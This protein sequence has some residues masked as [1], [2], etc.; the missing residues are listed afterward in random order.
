MTGIRTAHFTTPG[1]Y[2]AE[3]RS[4]KVDL[5]VTAGGD[6][7]GELTW[8]NLTGLQLLWGREN[9]PRIAFVALRPAQAYISLQVSGNKP[10]GFRGLNL[11][12][13][14][15]VIHGVEERAHHRTS[16]QAEWCWISLSHDKLA[17]FSKASIGLVIRPPLEARVHPAET[18]EAGKLR[19]A[20][21]RAREFAEGRPD[22]INDVEPA[23]VIQ[24]NLLSAVVK[25]LAA[26]N[27]E[28]PLGS[29]ARH[30]DIMSRFESAIAARD[31][32]HLNLA[33]ICGAIGVPERTLRLC[34]AEVLGV[35]P[36][37]Y[38]LLRRLNMA[39]SALSRANPQS[40]SV[41]EIARDHHFTELGRF[42]VA[43]RAI[44]DETPSATLRR[45]PNKSE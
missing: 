19:E 22:L 16:G 21:A 6:F 5:V 36:I 25:L 8:L 1:D 18:E 37:R 38:F 24:E 12:I 31:D 29:R 41:A 39:R 3:I 20:L 23:R 30:A 32:P 10:A 35:S 2:A 42:A 11:N 4:A 40:T 15:V 7:R 44:F 14:D 26:K 9:L 34:C 17:A 45:R 13:G 27:T 43:Y 28:K 33:E